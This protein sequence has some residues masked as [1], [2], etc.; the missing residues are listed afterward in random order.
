MRKCA[1]ALC[2]NARLGQARRPLLCEAQLLRRPW[3]DVHYWQSQ[4]RCRRPPLQQRRTFVVQSSGRG[5]PYEVL[6]LE[7]P[8]SKQQVQDAYHALALRWHPDRNPGDPEAEERFK[9]VAAAY[10][11]LRDPSRA[12]GASGAAHDFA[13]TAGM[14]REEADMIFREVFGSD[15]LEEMVAVFDIA[16]RI[17]QRAYQQI[18]EKYPAAESATQQI[19]VN[20]SGVPVVRTVVLQYGRTEVHEQQVTNEEAEELAKV[21][22][23]A[24]RLAGLAAR[25]VTARL[26]SELTTTVSHNIK[27]SV[28]GVVAGGVTTAGKLAEPFIPSFAHAMLPDLEKLAQ[29]N[30]PVRGK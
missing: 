7:R 19:I 2:R 23:G 5:D 1:A 30:A 14:T 3:H 16:E 17:Q 22:L 27:S 28:Y 13:Q 29:S 4:V 25:D 11:A 12:A 9:Q 10:Q 21:S 8:A 6:G 24:L 15:T 20:A 26:A 18:R